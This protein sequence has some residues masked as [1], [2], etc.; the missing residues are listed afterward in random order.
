MPQF[1]GYHHYPVDIHSIKSVEAL[2]NIQEPFIKNLYDSFNENEKLL[3]KIVTLFHD[4]GKGRRQDHS[5]VG[6]KLIAPF[7]KK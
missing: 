4:S 5:E 6:A 3:L 2:E 7:A 1:D